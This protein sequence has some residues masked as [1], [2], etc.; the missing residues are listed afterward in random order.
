M[1]A[2]WVKRASLTIVLTLAIISVIISGCDSEDEVDGISGASTADIERIAKEEL[3][4]LLD[5]Q[6]DILVIDVRSKQEYALGHIPDAISMV[7]PDEI[8]SRHQE[9]PI[10]KTLVFY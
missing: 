2:F 1:I 10:D 3:K 9:L 6:A 4:A 8:R 7:Y 5:D